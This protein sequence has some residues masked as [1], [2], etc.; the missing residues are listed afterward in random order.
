M[1]DRL[2]GAA[3]EIAVVGQG[4]EIP[5]VVPQRRAVRTARQ[6]VAIERQIVG[7]SGVHQRHPWPARVAALRPGGFQ[8]LVPADGFQ[9][10]LQLIQPG[11]PS[12]PI[13]QAAPRE[14][15]AIAARH[16]L[17][18]CSRSMIVE[19][20]VLGRETPELPAGLQA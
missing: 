11:R 8:G 14:D 1:A 5:E 4:V 9:I 10:A 15:I 3:A 2:K 13:S 7:E 19:A 16:G 17:Q 18:L 12:L 6:A 20:V